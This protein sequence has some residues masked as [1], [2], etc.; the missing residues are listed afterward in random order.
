MARMG[1]HYVSTEH[2]LLTLPAKRGGR[3]T[4]I[5]QLNVTRDQILN[6]LSNIRGS[7]FVN[8]IRPEQTYASLERYGRNLTELGKA[9][10]LDPGDRQGRRD[11]QHDGGAGAA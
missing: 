1:D 11:S 8:S 6:V 10:K 3:P 7:Q 4:L 9:G 2:L 5:E